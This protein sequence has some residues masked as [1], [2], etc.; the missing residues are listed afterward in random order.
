V[1][2]NRAEA[3]VKICHFDDEA[4]RLV[5]KKPDKKVIDN[6]SYLQL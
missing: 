1:V 6:H 4:R 5:A 3:I 2:I